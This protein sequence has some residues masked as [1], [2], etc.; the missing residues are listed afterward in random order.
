MIFS[1]IFP[2]LLSKASDQKLLGQI[3][4]QEFELNEVGNPIEY[5]TTSTSVLDKLMLLYDM[6]GNAKDLVVVQNTQLSITDQEKIKTLYNAELLTLKD[7][8][9]LPDIKANLNDRAEITSFTCFNTLRPDLSVSF[10]IVKLYSVQ[11]RMTF[12]M[13]AETNKIYE[14]DINSTVNP[15]DMDFDNAY[16]YWQDYIG[17]SLMEKDITQ[18]TPNGSHSN[19]NNVFSPLYS[20]LQ[21]PE[22][23]STSD[24]NMVAEAETLEYDYTDGNKMV[25]YSFFNTKGN[26]SFTITWLFQ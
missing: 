2:L 7:K 25:T 23:N 13:D 1:V 18:E 10:Y 15:L 3:Y 4:V 9:L 24:D 26:K 20:M 6:R 14:L 5:E 12:T 21:E 11:Y 16:L 19:D 22:K 8:N 17:L